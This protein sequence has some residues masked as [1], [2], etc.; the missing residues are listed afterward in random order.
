MTRIDATSQEDAGIATVQIGRTEEVLRRTVSVTVTPGLRQIGFA[1]LQ[2]LQR[3][4]HNLIGLTRLAVQI[5]QIFGTLMDK[6]L[7]VTDSYHIV[8]R[9]VSDDL[10]SAVGH[11]YLST[12]GSA[13]HAFRLTILVPVESS[14]ILLVILEIGHIRTKVDIPQTLTVE[15]VTFHQEILAIIAFFRI[16]CGSPTPVVKLDDNFQLTVTIDISTAG[17]VGN[18]CR[19]QRAVGHLDFQP[20]VGQSTDSI[21]LRLLLATYHSRHRVLA[22]YGTGSIS[23]VGDIQILGNLRAV[24]VEIVFDIVVLL[25]HDTPRAED[26]TLH[27]YSHQTAI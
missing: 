4:F 14:Y 22:G 15:L 17:V 19:S 16:A 10:L 13:H 1:S 27:L 26:T 3:V 18:V 8:L 2:A 24:A 5:N 7:T 11:I 25:A 23:I 6:P 12:I 21:A 9:G 20:R